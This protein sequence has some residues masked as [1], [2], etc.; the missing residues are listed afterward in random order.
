MMFTAQSTYEDVLD[1]R[2][3]DL[4]CGCGILSIAST[5]LGSAYTLGVDLDP[6]A[7]LVARNNLASLDIS[8]STIDFI[9]ADLSS[10]SSFRDLFGGHSRNDSEEEPFFDTV[11]MNPPFG[12]KNKGI[13]IVF[14]EIACQMS[15]SAVYSLHKS[16]TRKFIEKKANEY[17][18][19]GEV[20][21]EMRYDLPKTMKIHKHKTLDIAVD[22][23]RFQRIR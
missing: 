10:S 5:L 3:L 23:W 20:I 14:L 6:D 17:G 22:F 9:Q 8:D 16:S 4:G 21:A 1:K 12:T 18:F 15:N 2:V 19:E 13:D 7:L 11:V